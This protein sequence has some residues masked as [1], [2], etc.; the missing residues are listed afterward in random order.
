MNMTD[1][2]LDDDG[3]PTAAAEKT[4]AAWS[5]TDFRGLMEYV[6]QAWHFG[7]WGWN[8]SDETIDGKAVRRY[9]ISTGGW[10]GNETL[11]DALQDNRLFWMM[12]WQQSR[13]GGHYV[14]EIRE[15]K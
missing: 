1:D 3:Y 5:Y 6:R 14:F 7:D 11:I 15:R 12:C 9:N 13:R 8:E 2:M 4:I 10:S